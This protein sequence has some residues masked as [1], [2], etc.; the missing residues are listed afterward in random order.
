VHLTDQQEVAA[1]FNGD[2]TTAL[3]VT[4]LIGM[5]VDAISTTQTVALDFDDPVWVSQKEA[6]YTG[7]HTFT[8]PDGSQRT[9]YVSYLLKKIG[10]AWYIE[11][12][13]S[14]PQPIQSKYRDFRSY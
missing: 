3:L 11:S 6:F 2:Y 8:D 9:V 12:V 10:G 13:G 7:R 1:H 14:S 4:G 5:T